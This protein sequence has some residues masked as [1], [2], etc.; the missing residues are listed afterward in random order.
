MPVETSGEQSIKRVITNW[1]DE[2]GRRRLGFLT[3]GIL[4][5]GALIFFRLAWLQVFKAESL[6]KKA[7]VQYRSKESLPS[8]R[9]TIY[10][11]AGRPLTENLGDWLSIGINPTHVGDPAKFARDLSRVTNKPAKSFQDKLK[12]K[13]QYVVLARQVSPDQAAKLKTLGWKF[14]AQTE[15]HRTYPQNALAGQ[16]IGFTNIDNQGI[17]GLELSFDELL[18][19]KAGWRIYQLDV[20]GRKHLDDELP[21][22]AQENGGDLVTTI[23]LSVQSILEEELRPALDY[24]HARKAAGLVMNPTTG[25]I[26]AMASLPGFDPNRVEGQPKEN[27]KNLPITEMFEPGSTFKVITAALLLDRGLV[28]PEDMVN[29]GNG[30]I[31]IY[32]KTIHDAHPYSQL[33]FRDV[34]VHSSN[35]G[36]IRMS[37]IIQSSELYRQICNLGF[38][39]RTGI[40]MQGEAVG[41]LPTVSNWSGLTKPNVVIGQGVTVTML[42]LAM[43]YAAIANDGVLM[44]PTVIRGVRT[45]E[46]ELERQKPLALRRVMTSRTARI[47]SD[48]LKGVVEDGTGKL[49]SVKGLAVAGKTGTPQLV[50]PEGGYYQDKFA[51]VFVGYFPAD[52][53][54]YLCLILLEDAQ[55]EKGEHMGGNVA[56][57]I[58]GSVAERIMGLRPDLYKYEKSDK[59]HQASEQIKVPDLALV[60]VAEAV[61]SLKEA[62]LVMERHG[63]GA[64]IYDQM[65]APGTVANPGDLV[66]VTLGPLERSKGTTMIM[67]VLTGLSLRDAVKKATEN[68]LAVK[69]SGTGRVMRQS[70][71]SGARVPMGEVCQLVGK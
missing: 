26:L 27:Q 24:Y 44:R 57:P 1:G 56:A 34:V 9:G 65:P 17:S 51:P 66:Q 50:K 18:H 36:M 46:D 68:G 28:D 62:G 15:I 58:F 40:E 22:Q 63:E 67:P 45:G 41:S 5:A 25:E 47:M 42:Q 16:L 71:S 48:F 38:L 35:I 21:S 43:A 33:S 31:V 32:G 39:G 19:G 55:G 53:P 23:D 13:A 20:E 6:R 8:F 59:K 61:R 70:P 49:A 12:R 7:S 29:C 52:K 30:R 3:L 4:I 10:D 69:V 37:E 64:V 54:E 2:R 11:R 14:D 60:S